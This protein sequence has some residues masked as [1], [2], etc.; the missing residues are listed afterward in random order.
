[1]NCDLIGRRRDKITQLC[2][3]VRQCMCVRVC[4]S[5]FVCVC[6]DFVIYAALIQF[7]KNRRQA[8]RRCQLNF[9]GISINSKS[10]RTTLHKHSDPLFLPHSPS[11]PP[12][13]LPSNHSQYGQFTANDNSNNNN[14]NNVYSACLKQRDIV[15]DLNRIRKVRMN[16]V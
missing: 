11:L 14:Y 9:T 16:D 6:Y 12:Y 13:S 4:M 10:C 2:V 1:M 5:V 3:S 7:D 15:I 8:D